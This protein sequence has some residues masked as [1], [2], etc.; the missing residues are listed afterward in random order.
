M[1]KSDIYEFAIKILGLYLVVSVIEHL[2]EVITYATILIQAQDKPEL[3][4]GFNQMPIFIVTIFNF[5]LLTAFTWI[6]IFKTR[7]LTSL[8]CTKEDCSETTGLFADKQTIIEIAIIL[9]GLMTIIW[10]IPEFGVKLKNYVFMAQN[11][12]TTTVNDKSFILIA[13][14]KILVGIIAVSYA[15]SISSYLSKEKKED[16]KSINE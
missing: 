7:K 15:K 10:T 8:I 14:L 2:R 16:D 1:K 11:S 5:L 4:D 12:F 6:L 9:V 3:F 13:G